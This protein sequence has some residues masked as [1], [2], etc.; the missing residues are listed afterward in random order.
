MRLQ[1]IIAVAAFSAVCSSLLLAANEADVKN[2]VTISSPVQTG[3]PYQAEV[4][5][6]AVFTRAGA[7]T[8]SYRCGQVNSPDKVVVV[9]E[10]PSGWAR[11][12][13]PAGSFSWVCKQN[14][15]IDTASPD[16][17]TVTVQPTRVWV[18]SMYYDPLN[19][20]E[21]QVKLNAGDKVKLLKEEVGD[22]YKIVPPQGA[23]L[24][25]S[26]QY[27]KKLGAATTV[28]GTT[29]TAVQTPE[30]PKEKEKLAEYRRL[31]TELD[32]E[33]VK[34]IPQQDYTAIRAGFEALAK[35]PEA[36]KAAKYA[37][38][39]LERI[40]RFELAAT[41]FADLKQQEKALTELRAKIDAEAQA[42][43][44]EVPDMGRYA[45]I[46]VFRQSMAYADRTGASRRY[47]VL[48]DGGS[49][50]CYAQPTGN[51]ENRD[52]SS[53]YDKK[54]GLIGVIGTDTSSSLPL[55]QFTDIEPV[56]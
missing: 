16:M 39:Q 44:D 53:F 12:E 6:N 38:I 52:F 14:V 13:P 18:G 25:I 9:E 19:S 33:R 36:G 49:I 20:N 11:I 2:T 35:D 15:T 22:Y 34:P 17:A 26:T 23:S 45:I 30:N 46:G 7:G 56:K 31:A 50:V 21:L 54:V 3:F 40:E 41:S 32:L 1:T 8:A 42:K 29:T 4:V 43:M 48:G 55:V 37:T 27:I 10:D 51:A 5:G 24:W 47:L 28:A